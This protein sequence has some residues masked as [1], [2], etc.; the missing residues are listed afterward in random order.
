M[1]TDCCQL[2]A[3]DKTCIPLSRS[4]N[5]LR[6]VSAGQQ[7]TRTS[8]QGWERI[9]GRVVLFN[10]LLEVVCGQA[11]LAK[12]VMHTPEVVEVEGRQTL[13]SVRGHRRVGSTTQ[14]LQG[15]LEVS[16]QVFHVGLE[17]VGTGGLCVCAEK[18][19]GA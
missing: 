5:T 4:G 17:V 10:G 6:S 9:E 2:R 3:E 18:H 7:D 19:A 12:L 1:A 13:P 8:V 11:V 14:H 15:F 16:T